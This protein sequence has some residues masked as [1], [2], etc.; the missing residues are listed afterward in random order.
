[1]TFALFNW[2]GTNPEP[3]V[4]NTVKWLTKSTNSGEK[5][6]FRLPDQTMVWLNSKS[7]L[8]FPESFDSTVRLVVLKGEAFFEVSKDIDHPFQV[9]ADSLITTAIGTSFNVMARSEKDVKVSLLTGKVMIN[10]QADTL[11]YFL[12]PGKELSYNISTGSTK[13]TTF[14]EEVVTGWRFG[15]LS[16]KRSTL[17]QVLK[18]LE[19]W[20]GV[21]ISII[22]SASSDWQFTG[23]FENQTLE[24]ILNSMSNIES[25]SY[26]IKE[27]KVF[28]EFN[29]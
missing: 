22:G 3:A 16:F 27:K 9:L 20:Y 6:T 4:E 21:E 23:K 17:R 14:N 26:T 7:S 1:M 11:S 5:L 15:K 29:P 10:Y 25:F 8:S 2:N 18:T 13:T 19:D 12:L 28:I 24:N